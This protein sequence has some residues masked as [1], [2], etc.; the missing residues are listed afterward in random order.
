MSDAT[1]THDL[2]LFDSDE[3]L[4]E[5]VAPF[6]ADGI[7]AGDRV[8]VHGGTGE[9]GALHDAV[10]GPG[11]EIIGGYA[12][13]TATLADFQRLC[14]DAAGR[15]VRAVA[16][17]PASASAAVRAQWMRYEALVS[18]ALEPYR[19]AGLCLYDTRT[20][21]PDLIER[22]RATHRHTRGPAGRRANADARPDDEVLREIDAAHPWP[23]PPEGA[24][25]VL[26]LDLPG[27]STGPA[28]SAA[29]HSVRE[30]LRTTG[31]RDGPAE[32]YLT[33]IGEVLTNAL[34]HGEGPVQIRLRTAHD[35][36]W[37]TVTDRGP[38]IDD[39]YTGI[40]SPL[41]GG[42]GA[43]GA[44]LWIARQLCDQLTIDHAPVG[45]ARVV[46]RRVA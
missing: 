6:V 14:E 7:A 18:R 41:P 22:A 4:I 9:L 42:S 29:R 23:R 35:G 17:I 3:E 5:A 21:P 39:P 44:G 37:C 30:A 1:C 13:P 15:G 31:L 8:L 45:G 26:A 11:V 20:T 16:P 36:W 32:E 34:L 2:V 46:L 12:T 27:G 40:D 28:L 38:G 24:S 25:T 33:A 19:F 43:A 10:A